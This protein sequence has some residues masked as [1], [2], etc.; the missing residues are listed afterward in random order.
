MPFTRS[1]RQKA[2]NVMYTASSQ[3]CPSLSR[4]PETVDSPYFDLN[5]QIYYTSNFTQNTFVPPTSTTKRSTPWL[6]LE[7]LILSTV[8]PFTG[9]RIISGHLRKIKHGND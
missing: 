2:G 1:A 8:I 6:T 3:E 7:I 5:L 9:F 4:F